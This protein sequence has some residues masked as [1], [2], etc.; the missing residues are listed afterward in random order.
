MFSTIQKLLF[1]QSVSIHHMP[2]FPFRSFP[3]TLEAYLN[4]VPG[5]TQKV[6]FTT[7]PGLKVA[8]LV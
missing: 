8:F 6:S 3:G 2:Y 7:S 1:P 4:L 5:T